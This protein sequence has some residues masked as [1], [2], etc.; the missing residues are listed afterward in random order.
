MRID[1]DKLVAF[2]MACV[3]ATLLAL[4]IS[5][6]ANFHHRKFIQKGGTIQRDTTQLLIIDTIKVNGRDSII[7]INH[8]VVCPDLVSPKT[9]WQTRIE[10]KIHRD[11]LRLERYKIKYKYKTVKVQEQPKRKKGN[12]WGAVV[13]VCMLALLLYKMK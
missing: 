8:S 10:Y 2:I 5:C 3:F 6:S 7:H 9:R 12:F 13:V 1:I 4:L 11:T